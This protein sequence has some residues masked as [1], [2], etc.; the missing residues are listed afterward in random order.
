MAIGAGRFRLVR[1]LL[2]ESLMLAIAGGAAGIAVGWAGIRFIAKYQIPTDLPIVFDLSLDH[3]VVW[4]SLMASLASA[5][6]F[7]LAPAIQNTR[8]N[9]V[10]A[11]KAADVDVPGQKRLIGRNILVVGQIAGSMVLL[12]VSTLMVRSFQEQF[13]K[14]GYRTDHVMTMELDPS[15]LRLDETQIRQFYKQLRE[16]VRATAGVKQVAMAQAVPMG[17]ALNSITFVPDGFEMPRGKE[18]FTSLM[19]VVDENY[20]DLMHVFIARGRGFRAIDI[21]ESPQVAIVNEQFTQHY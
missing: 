5:L 20:L 8:T 4:F 11:L 2:T 19:N 13:K 15:L 17:A 3:R 18:N 16:R 14:I 10:D 21:A 1:L 9:L 7:G 6:L 12:T